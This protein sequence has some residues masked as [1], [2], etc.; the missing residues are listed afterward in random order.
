LIFVLALLITHIYVH[1][2]DRLEKKKRK[3]ER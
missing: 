3:E 1:R 2:F